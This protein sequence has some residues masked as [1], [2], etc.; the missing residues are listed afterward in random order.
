MK[1]TRKPVPPLK[2][3]QPLTPEQKAHV[4]RGL[5]IFWQEF[6]GAIRRTAERLKE[7]QQEKKDWVN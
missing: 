2:S 4:S 5:G 6:F 7:E 3:H 1:E